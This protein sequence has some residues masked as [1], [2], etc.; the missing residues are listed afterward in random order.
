MN[1]L[2]KLNEGPHLD[3]ATSRQPDQWLAAGSLDLTLWKVTTQTVSE[4][5]TYEMFI[6][7]NVFFN[8][9][10]SIANRRITRGYLDRP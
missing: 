10:V 9:F 3:P 5:S 6:E 4:S 8:V 2:K 7:V 1:Q